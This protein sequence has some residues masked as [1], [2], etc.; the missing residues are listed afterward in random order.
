MLTKATSHY[1]SANV[2]NEVNLAASLAEPEPIFDTDLFT[3]YGFAILEKPIVMPDLDPDTG[4]VHPTIVTHIRAIGWCKEDAIFSSK[5]D[6]F[7][8]GVSIFLYTTRD[9]YEDGFYRTAKAAG[10]SALPARQRRAA[11][12]RPRA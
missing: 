4:L 5:D 10:K 8:P 7:H 12:P 3:P 2:I 9:D 1:V 11:A 6:Q